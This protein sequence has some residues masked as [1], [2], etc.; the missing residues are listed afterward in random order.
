MP[1]DP[2]NCN[3]PFMFVKIPVRPSVIEVVDAFVPTLNAPDPSIL[4]ILFNCVVPIGLFTN[5]FS[6]LILILL[7]VLFVYLNPSTVISNSLILFEKLRLFLLNVDN[8]ILYI[9]INKN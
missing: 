9:F 4:D 3:D 1:D 2:F 7:P 5:T 8:S 6:Q